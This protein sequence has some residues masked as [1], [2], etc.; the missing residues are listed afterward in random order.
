MRRMLRR[1]LT[2]ARLPEPQVQSMTPTRIYPSQ[3]DDASM[4]MYAP[5][6]VSEEHFIWYAINVWVAS[7]VNRIVESA[8]LSAAHL[9]LEA[10]E[11]QRGLRTDNRVTM[12]YATAG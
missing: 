12:A 3:K 9:R 8:A 7:A 10:L 4:F 1:D 2:P 11:R 6:T 5:S